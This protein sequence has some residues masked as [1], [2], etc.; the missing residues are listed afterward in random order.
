VSGV[1]SQPVGVAVCASDVVTSRDVFAGPCGPAVLVP[2]GSSPVDV[3][4]VAI[5]HFTASDGSI[6]DCGPGDPPPCVVAVGTEDGSAF[7]ATRVYY[8][9]D[10]WLWATP[11]SALVDGQ[12]VELASIG[13]PSSYDGPPFWIFPTTGQ[14]NVAQCDQQVTDDRTILGIFT[15]CAPLPG[16]PTPIDDPSVPIE[17]PVQA[18]I[19]RILGGTTNCAAPDAPCVLVLG[20]LDS[21]GNVE[22]HAT[23]PLSFTPG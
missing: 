13:V 22:L 23:R 7:A 15:H 3:D 6:V 20:R 18:T 16:V 2:A 21:S 10:P 5:H 12:Q 1:R 14:W 8:S 17:I 9:L 19:T 4:L 11:N